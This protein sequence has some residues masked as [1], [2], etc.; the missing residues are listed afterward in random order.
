TL[1]PHS[2]PRRSRAAAMTRRATAVSERK[3]PRKR[4][5]LRTS[6]PFLA[7]EQQRYEFPL[8][9]RE[10]ILSVLEDEGVPVEPLR[11]GE[12]LEIR[13]EEMEAFERRLNAM[14]R[15]GQI[16]R[17]R[18][19][20]LCVVEKLGLIRGRVVGHPDGFGFLVP[21]DGGGD[22]FLSPWEMTRVFHGDRVMVRVTGLD[23]R[24]R[25]EGVIVE[26][27]ERAHT[28][29]VGRLHEKH[30]VCYLVPEDRR[31]S[32][33]ILIPREACNGAQSG[34]VVVAEIIEQPDRHVKPVGR[35][36]EV[37]GNYADPGM[38]VEIALRKHELPHVF[39]RAAEA[40]AKKFSSTVRKSD[41]KGHEDITHLPLVTID[42]ETAKDFDDAVY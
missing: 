26:V 16:M 41:W 8:P 33:D 36:V 9:S 12:L 3:K 40:Q 35:I 4:S 20:A 31:L 42:G 19:G 37:L 28:R 6:D 30:G 24:G 15:E 1:V 32:Q 18:A 27:L 7:R 21:E 11:L 10:W 13:A 29:V 25:R 2:L 34:Q 39:P 17:N 38:E 23:R 22:L 5:G 14:E